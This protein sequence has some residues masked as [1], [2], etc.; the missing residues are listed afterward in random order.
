MA[1]SQVSIK[2][3]VACRVDTGFA[4]WLAEAD[5]SLAVTTYQAG[6]LLMIGWDGQRPS[7]NA[8]NFQRV[9]GIDTQGDSLV[10]ASDSEIRCFQNAAALATDFIPDQPGR[11]DA[12]YLER[13]I[14]HT[15]DLFVHDLAYTRHGLAFV[16]TRF[17]CIA[18]VSHEYHFIPLWQPP[19]IEQIQPGDQ[20]HLNGL[21]VADGELKAVTALGHSSESGGWRAN[22][23]DGGIVIDV[24]SNEIILTGLAMPHSPRVHQDSLWLLNSGKGE[25]LHLPF[26]ATRAETV[27]QLSTY[28]RG[29]AF[30]RGMAVVGLCK[31]R[32]KKVFGGLPIENN[33]PELMCGIA[34]VDI[35]HGVCKGI[36]EFT[37]GV[38]E[39][40]D[41]RVLP[42][43]R[44]ASI[45]AREHPLT[46]GAFTA[47]E[48]SYWIRAENG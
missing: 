17:S 10:L 40:Y 20:C 2:G 21:A 31:I 18:T 25:L 8:R 37:S 33:N 35:N 26:G 27:C 1:K 3:D 23:A 43:V 45:Y 4:Q 14:Y 6:K 48:F 22:K 5:C 9:M 24:P 13:A 7:L 32:E 29:L 42:S 44:K 15:G 12:L 39:I 47:P 36:F 11:Y 30:H 28:L 41:I 16:N 46:E 34:V 38:E 19:F